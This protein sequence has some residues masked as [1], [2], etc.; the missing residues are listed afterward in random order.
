M[1]DIRVTIKTPSVGSP[2]P[3]RSYGSAFR[4]AAGDDLAAS[5]DALDPP[6]RYREASV[7]ETWVRDA[8]DEL[9]PLEAQTV[10]EQALAL[11]IPG[12]GFD[13]QRGIVWAELVRLLDRAGYDALTPSLKNRPRRGLGAI[14]TGPVER[15]E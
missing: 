7:A 8:P 15:P 4:E 9:E 12:L 10:L 14:F 3:R 6:E 1:R 5:L 11:R 2:P 13:A